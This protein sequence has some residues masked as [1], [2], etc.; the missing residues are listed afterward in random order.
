MHRGY[1]ARFGRAAL[2][3]SGI[4]ELGTGFFLFLAEE[5]VGARKAVDEYFS[6]HE[7]RPLLNRID[8][9]GGISVKP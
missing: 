7:L 4:S 9:T 5:A 1:S 6:S 3:Y 2:S 8:Q